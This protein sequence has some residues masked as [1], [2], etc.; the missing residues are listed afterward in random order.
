MSV[1]NSKLDT[2]LENRNPK[3]RIE[4]SRDSV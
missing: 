3:C 4:G 1:R 2:M